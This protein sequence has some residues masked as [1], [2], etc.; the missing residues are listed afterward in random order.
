MLSAQAWERMWAPYDESTYMQALAYVRPSDIVLDIGA[1]DLRLARRLAVQAR[2]VYALE[3]NA[4]MLPA[5]TTL[6]DNVQMICAD[7][8]TFPFPT[9]VTLA[10][11]LM[12][13]CQHLSLYLDKLLAAGCRYLVTNARWGVGVERIDLWAA[14]VPFTAV[15][16]GWYACWCGAN[17]FVSGP[18]EKLTA[19]VESITHEVY[20]CP[21]CDLELCDIHCNRQEKPAFVTGFISENA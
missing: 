21:R 12:R 17:G 4:A 1:G 2:Y 5:V 10:V 14:R 3:M 20:H 18:P 9:D 15:S 6:P 13:H 8:R 11:L 19:A 16:I 7:A